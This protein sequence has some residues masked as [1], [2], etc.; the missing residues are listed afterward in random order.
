MQCVTLATSGMKSE[1]S[2]MA[3]GVHAWRA[4]GVPCW[5]E[6]TPIPMTVTATKSSAAGNTILRARR[7]AESI[8]FLLGFRVGSTVRGGNLEHDRKTENQFS[9]KFRF[10]LEM[11]LLP[12]LAGLKAQ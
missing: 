8:V 4:S 5:A 7:M 12:M 3:S 2:R 1:Q 10:R 9:E 11:A 6:A